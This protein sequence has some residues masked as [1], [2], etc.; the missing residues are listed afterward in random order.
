MPVPDDK[1]IN[2]FVF[3]IESP[4]AVDLYHRRS[5]GNLIQQAVNL[6]Q[7]PCSVVTAINLESFEAALKVGLTESMRTFPD[8]IPMLHISAHGNQ[9]G[10]QLS[11]GES[12][13][14]EYLSTLLMP[15]NTALDNNLL[16]CM[17]CC[18]GY[19]GTIMAK[20][21]S[22]EKYPFF[23]IVA[24]SEKPLWSDTA[25]AYSTFYHLVAKGEFISDAVNAM[26]IASGNKTFW[27]ETAV[28]S[29]QSYIDY[30]AKLNA[31]D[32]QVE[33][34]EN[35]ESETPEHLNKMRKLSTAS[36]KS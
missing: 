33:L 12:I 22:D 23:A 30:I 16:I 14:W 31:E 17:S 1:R 11:S 24:N 21:L 20:E 32:V 27:L 8:M 9:D 34:D 18:E 13:P 4:S 28:E 5:E 2:F 25:V 10:I 6:N 7:I 29:R 36:T 19:S 15:I 35:N 26:R 3:V